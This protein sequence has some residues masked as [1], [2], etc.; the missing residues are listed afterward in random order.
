MRTDGSRVGSGAPG[1]DSG[2]V[3]PAAMG[4]EEAL[5]KFTTDLTQQARD[6][7]MD[8]IV[9]RDEEIR[10]V[11]DILMRR[12]Q[13][14]PILTGEAGVGKSRLAAS[15]L[16]GVNQ[17]AIATLRYFCSPHRQASPLHP[18]IQQ[19]EHAVGF[20][21]DDATET[22]L[23]KLMA[24]LGDVPEQDLVLIAELLNLPAG[25]RQRRRYARYRAGRHA[26]IVRSGATNPLRNPCKTDIC[27][28][29]TQ[30]SLAHG[31]SERSE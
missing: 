25:D 19:I 14:N 4:K 30:L 6:G 11:V 1:E 31:A 21:R 22:K 13:N 27:P 26:G 15:I 29:R 9:G 20:A 8:P 5:K 16:E 3:A 23:E 28:R 17:E 10:Q 7:K 18:C 12:R 2:A 24:A